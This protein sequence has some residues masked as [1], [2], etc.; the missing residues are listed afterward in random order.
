M[1]LTRPF[2]SALIVVLMAAVW[3]IFAPVQF[4]GSVTYV[5]VAGASMEPELH[6]GDLVVTRQA[7]S[8]EVGDIT[9]YQHPQV[10]PVIHRIIEREGSN[11]TLK[12]DN[13]DWIDSYQPANAEILG[14]SWLYIPGAAEKLLWLRTPV[15][16]SLLSLSIG[17]MFIITITKNHEQDHQTGKQSADMFTRWYRQTQSLRL[18]DWV[19]PL[20]ILLF[21]SIFL[22]AFAFTRPELQSVPAD[23]QYDHRG[24]FSYNAPAAPSLYTSD[25]IQTGEAIFHELIRSIDLTYEY[26][27]A[28][29]A[30][31]QLSG[32]IQ[33]LLRVGEP[34]GWYREYPLAI[35]D[36]EGDSFTIGATIDL[37]QIKRYLS[38]V[39]TQTGLERRTFD[40][41]VI[42][43]TQIDGTVE[44][45]PLHDRFTNTLHFKL[46]E[47]QLFLTE[48]G[49][50]DEVSDPLNPVR[51]GFIPHQSVVDNSLSIL[52][53]ELSVRQARRIAVIAGIVSL[54][55]IAL[56]MTPTM[57]VSLRSES[58]RITLLHAGNLLDV[59][60]IP[61]DDELEWVEVRSI[62][63]LVKVSE[64]TGGLILHARNGHDHIYAIKDGTTGYLLTIHDPNGVDKIEAADE[65]KTDPGA[66]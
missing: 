41:D 42:A 63:D 2:K 32:T 12:G 36:F 21:A 7:S 4:G 56:I 16:L 60:A 20:G 13:N 43:D 22:G 49:P 44:G 34:N 27:F 46:D 66:K 6:Q 10:G 47:I 23:I 35:N 26:S 55:F 45:L 30:E 25:K 48:H 1:N 57:A 62:D 3:V 51:S 61:L 15:G 19:F 28:S 33:L 14:K 5:M 65:G 39:Q 24:S 29:E 58:E 53:L 50:T 64:T 37:A 17:I 40:I 59:D 54:L 18:G 52:G 9:T 31:T 8:Y 38:W 11:Y